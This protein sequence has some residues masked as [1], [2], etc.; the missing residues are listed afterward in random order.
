MADAFDWAVAERYIKEAY[1][2]ESGHILVGWLLGLKVSG[3]DHEVTRGCRNETL[4]GNFITGRW[5][6]RVPKWF[7]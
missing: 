1:P 2:H 7:G 6:I 3:L 4:P 5:L